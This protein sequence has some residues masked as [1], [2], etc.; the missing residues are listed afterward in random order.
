MDEARYSINLR[1]NL[2]GYD[3]QVTM[4]DDNDCGELMEK[5]LNILGKLHDIGAT[6]VRRWEEVKGN[7]NGN[8][9]TESRPSADQ[10]RLDENTPPT[11]RQCG[12]SEG[13]EH[14]EFDRGGK[15]RKAWK[16]QTCEK[17][18]YEKNGK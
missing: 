14:I 6:P 1:F 16:C 17:W 8:G 12:S 4:R 11:C 18:Y 3:S 9:K 13:M 15:P 5:Y 2:R 7:G 10:P